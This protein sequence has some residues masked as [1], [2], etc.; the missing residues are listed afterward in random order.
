[1]NDNI[2]TKS[3]VLSL[4]LVSQFLFSAGYGEALTR[5]WLNPNEG[6]LCD[7]MVLPHLCW[8]VLYSHILICRVPSEQTVVAPTP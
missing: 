6:G 2:W 7:E 3:T 4:I 1:M 5:A 8:E